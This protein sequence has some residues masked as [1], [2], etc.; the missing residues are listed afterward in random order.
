MTKFITTTDTHVGWT[1]K[2]GRNVPI[3][4][5]KAWNAILKFASDFKPNAWVD[6]GD[7]IDCGPI[8]HWNKDRLRGNE[9]LRLIDEVEAYDKL[10]LTEM[11]NILPTNGIKHWHSGNHIDWVDQFVERNPGLEGI[12]S[13]EKLLRLKE[14]KWNIFRSN[15]EENFISRLGKLSFTHGDKLA[16]GGGTNAAFRAVTQYERNIRM[17]HYHRF[18]VATKVSS[19]DI[20]DKRTG[21]VIP[22]LCNKNPHFARNRPNAWMT[23]FLFGYVFED[24]S[25]N[26]VPVI[27]TDGKFC[28]GGKVYRG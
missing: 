17:G 9:T 11:E 16:G 12:I 18:E 3:H 28:V 15:D 13:V 14:R 10:Y 5:E 24:G 21:M 6:L 7:G 25:F 27:I 23:G 19:S 4:D 26:D 1:R 20:K 2:H 22:A 8:S